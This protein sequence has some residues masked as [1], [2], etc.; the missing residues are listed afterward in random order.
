MQRLASLNFDM[1]DETN[2]SAYK[3]YEKKM[4]LT[5]QL[6]AHKKDMQKAKELVLTVLY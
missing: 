3:E 5:D 6:T 1:N 2:A 4:E